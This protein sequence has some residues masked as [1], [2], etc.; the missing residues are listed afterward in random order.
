[1]SGYN[2]RCILNIKNAWKQ[3]M[4]DDCLWK[5]VYQIKWNT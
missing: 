3:Q 2:V 5:P 4:A 1:M